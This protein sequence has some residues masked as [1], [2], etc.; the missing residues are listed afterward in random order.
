MITYAQGNTS[1]EAL[2][3]T[4]S[5]TI[6]LIENESE[7]MRVLMGDYNILKKCVL[8]S[9]A[10]LLPVFGMGFISAAIGVMRVQIIKLLTKQEGQ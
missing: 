6:M 10:F 5:D 2:A 8:P 4:T 3:S 1:V 9:A 7:A